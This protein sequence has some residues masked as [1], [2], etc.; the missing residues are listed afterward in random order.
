MAPL[1]LPGL[2]IA[3]VERRDAPADRGAVE[4]EP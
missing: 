2:S 3:I 1:A 4:P